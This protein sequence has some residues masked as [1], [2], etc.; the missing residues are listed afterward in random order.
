[1]LAENVM[2]V[3]IDPWQ[4]RRFYEL[5]RP[6]RESRGTV[7]VI[8]EQGKVLKAVHTRGIPVKVERVEDPVKLARELYQSYLSDAVVIWEKGSLNKYFVEIQRTY[9]EKQDFDDYL[10]EIF[11]LLHRESYSRDLV[12]YRG[13]EKGAGLYDFNLFRNFITTRVPDNSTLIL[14]VFENNTVW[15]SWIVGVKGGKIVLISTFDSLITEGLRIRN[16]RND[17]KQVLNLV[18]KKF[19][20]PWLGLFMDKDVF[21][22]LMRTED[23][24]SYLGRELASRKIIGEPL[25]ISLL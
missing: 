20:S 23:K 14:G 7:Y 16:W 5:I 21:E 2:I 8:H 6:V 17:Y 11:Q 15:C 3:D 24:L 13:E 19:F 4:C 9:R 25:K 1:M 22:E 18:S 10:L 12:S